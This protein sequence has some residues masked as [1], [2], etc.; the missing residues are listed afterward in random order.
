MAE[1]SADNLG[2]VHLT[3][4]KSPTGISGLDDVTDGG[5][6]R[7]RLTLVCGGAGCGK[8][9]FGLEFIVRG[10]VEFDEPG[11]VLSFD[12][13]GNELAQNVRSLGFDLKALTAQNK[14]AIVYI[15]MDTDAQVVGNFDLSPLFMRLDRAV[16]K[17]GAK[18][19]LL[20]TL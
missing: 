16:T 4:P 18:R 9:L 5:I 2:T 10:A 6:P 11:V 12:E 1:N 8:T 14:L 3:L 7:H 13:T 20:D 17:V 19:I 15:P